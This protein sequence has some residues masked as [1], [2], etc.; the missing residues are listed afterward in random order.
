VLK[1]LSLKR[2]PLFATAIYTG[3]RKGELLGLRKPDVD[4]SAR[5]LK[6]VR[7]YDRDT[8][9]GGHA[10][11]I[12]IAAKLTPWLEESRQTSPSDLVFPRT[13]GSMMGRDTDLE[14]MLRRALGRAGIATGYT[15]TCRRKG[16]HYRETAPDAALRHCPAHG[17]KLWPTPRVR[18]I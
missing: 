9:K 14:G 12:P 3:L 1:A 11:A 4:L 15:H 10:E 8:T 7:S 13:D 6:V 16:C 2:R 5:L 18:P 17:W